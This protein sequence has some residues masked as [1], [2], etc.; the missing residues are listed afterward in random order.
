MKV[1]VACEYS[2]TVRDA[3]AA[4]GHDAWSC[5]VIPSDKPGNHYQCDIKKVLSNQWDLLIAFP[6][7]TQ[8][9]S[10]GARWWKQKQQEQADAIQFVKNLWN[11]P[12]NKIAIEKPIG[13]LSTVWQH[14]TQIVQ[15]YWFGDPYPKSTCLWLK[16]LPPLVPTNTVQP[17]DQRIWRCPPGP[18]RW[19]IRSLTPRGLAEAM[20]TQWS[21]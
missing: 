11:F 7:C 6:P 13:I 17:T 8:L 5:D 18:N 12:I 4:K 2:G 16:N 15:P 14:P 9:C 10:S 19:K 3:F 21:T 20:A 1:L